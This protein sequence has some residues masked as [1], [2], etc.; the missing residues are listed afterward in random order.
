MNVGRTK[1]WHTSIASVACASIDAAM[2]IV[3]L[4]GVSFRGNVVDFDRFPGENGVA[5]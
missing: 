4:S 5:E 2:V 1:S 3:C